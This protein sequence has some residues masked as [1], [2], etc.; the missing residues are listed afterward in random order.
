MKTLFLAL[1]VVFLSCPVSAAP[2][3]S[4]SCAAFGGQLRVDFYQPWFSPMYSYI[5]AAEGPV[6]LPIARGVCRKNAELREC[7][8]VLVGNQATPYGM[9]LIDTLPTT[10]GAVFSLKLSLLYQQNEPRTIT[11]ACLKR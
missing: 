4:A 1:L 6:V 11:L 7:H 10:P 3:P 5:F 8:Y 9:T 2:R